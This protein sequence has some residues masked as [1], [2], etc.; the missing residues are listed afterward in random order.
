[1]FI[2]RPIGPCTSGCLLCLSRSFRP[3]SNRHNTPT[4]ENWMRQSPSRICGHGR[5]SS[6]GAAARRREMEEPGNAAQGAAREQLH[7]PPLV[8][9]GVTRRAAT[10]SELQWSGA[11]RDRETGS[12]LVPGV[13]S[14]VPCPRCL[15]GSCLAAITGRRD[16]GFLHLLPPGLRSPPHLD[17]RPCSAQPA[18]SQHRHRR[19]HRLAPPAPPPATLC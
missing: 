18:R 16:R 10:L 1:M 13:P 12:L 4:Q 9:G 3:H 17:Q 5:P 11:L 15:N 14:A 8:P 7:L 2:I 19:Q 6:G